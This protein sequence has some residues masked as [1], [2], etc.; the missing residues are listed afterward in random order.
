MKYRTHVAGCVLLGSAVVALKAES[1][2]LAAAAGGTGIA[3]VAI[4]RRLLNRRE[5]TEETVLPFPPEMSTLEF[6]PESRTQ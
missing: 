5:R 4:V 2:S 1:I 3:L 6:P